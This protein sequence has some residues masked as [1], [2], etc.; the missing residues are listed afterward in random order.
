MHIDLESSCSKTWFLKPL[1]IFPQWS[2]NLGFK[3]EEVLKLCW[4]PVF[5]LML[6][7]SSSSFSL[8]SKPKLYHAFPNLISCTTSVNTVKYTCN[9]ILTLSSCMD[10]QHRCSTI[11]GESFCSLHR[12]DPAILFCKRNIY[13]LQKKLLW[14]YSTWQ[15]RFAMR[16]TNDPHEKFCYT[17]W[18][19]TGWI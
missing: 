18:S 7:G 9:D 10:W 19:E 3:K 12:R 16:S 4:I 15:G 6:T 5:T 14:K 1:S 17:K 11:C 8:N 13:E 2:Q